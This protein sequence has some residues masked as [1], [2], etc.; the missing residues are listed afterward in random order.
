MAILGILFHEVGGRRTA[1]GSIRADRRGLTLLLALAR[2][3]PRT[4]TRPIEVIFAAAGGQQLDY[5]GS[6]AVVRRLE[7]ERPRK[8]SL[9]LLFFDP[10]AGDAHSLVP[11]GSSS[12]G[13]AAL[14]GDAASS[15]W[16]PVRA[17]DPWSHSLFWP[18]ERKVSATEV[19]ALQGA[20]A[21]HVAETLTPQ[22][23]EHAAQLATEIAL[24]WAKKAKQTAGS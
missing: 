20:H 22:V 17:H 7:L 4:R 13:T 5:A 10:G 15:L 16:I 12:P 11:I 21:G 9:L 6:R 19:I 1:D 8:P 24:R 14:A 3:W 18:L 2:S 23:L